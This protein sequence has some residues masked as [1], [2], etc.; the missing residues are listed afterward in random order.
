MRVF[1]HDIAWRHDRDGF[2][3]E[4]KVAA[5][6]WGFVDGK[7]QTIYP[8]DSW[9]KQYTSEPSP[10]FHDIFRRDGT[11][12]D[13]AEVEYIKRLTGAAQTR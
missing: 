4:Q 9:E 3:K 2:L 1:L 7:T 10:W 5:Y 12:Y 6:N 8:W 11:P 13:P